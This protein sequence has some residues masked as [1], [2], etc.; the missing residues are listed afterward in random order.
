MILEDAPVR[1][2]AP[3]HP[4]RLC[5]PAHRR[6]RCAGRRQRPAV[7]GRPAHHGLLLDRLRVLSARPADAL[8][9][10]RPR[11]VRGGRD[12]YVPFEA[13]VPGRIVRTFPALLDAIRRDDY[14]LEKVA[15]FAERHFAHLDGLVH[16]S[17]HRPG[18]PR[19]LTMLPMT[20]PRHLVDPPGPRESPGPC[21]AAGGGPGHGARAP[22]RR[23]PRSIRDELARRT[24]PIPSSSS[25]SADRWLARPARRVLAGR[26]VGAIT[27]GR[28]PSSS[29]T[30]T[31]SRSTRVRRAPGRRSSRRGTPGR[32][33]EIR[34]Q[35]ARQVVRRRRAPDRAVRI[36]GNYDVCIV[37]SCGRPPSL[38]RGVPPAARPLRDGPRR[39][40]HGRAV[41]RRAHRPPV[42]D[43]RRP[44]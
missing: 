24:P 3:G 9:R 34:L 13:F 30:T 12:V 38:Q 25:R 20:A 32:V 7:R 42:A 2:P 44:L 1:P 40:A 28:P 22:H 11:R 10:A 41:R 31:T 15:A 43:L 39:A 5:R 26:V 19:P 4:G 36:H 8:L 29:S 33:Q 27:S 35:R 37:V 14:E 18:H 23:E 6:L 16:G 17:R 21:R